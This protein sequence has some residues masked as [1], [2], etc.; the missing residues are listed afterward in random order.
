MTIKEELIERIWNESMEKSGCFF[1]SIQICLLLSVIVVFSACATKKRI[2]QTERQETVFASDSSVVH[3]ESK[4]T[5]SVYHLYNVMEKEKT[6]SERI[7]E[8]TD[9]T[10]LVVDTDGNVL[11]QEI[12]HD[13]RETINRYREYDKMQKDSVGRDRRMTDSILFY[14][15]QIDSL[16][17]VVKNDN[18]NVTEIVKIPKIA[19]I[20]L[21]FLALCLIFV[22]VKLARWIKTY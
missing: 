15:S 14:R 17:H 11:K 5:T 19:K 2:T 13:R 22:F 7:V 3:H 16:R 6:D 10:V 4:D 8:K 12:W 21:V 20:S 9:S 18:M 1:R